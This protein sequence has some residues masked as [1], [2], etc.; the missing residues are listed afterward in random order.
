ML[1]T[2][3]ALIA[4]LAEAEEVKQVAKRRR[5]PRNIWIPIFNKRIGEVVAAA[6]ADRWQIPVAL[7]ELEDG[8]V[9]RILMRNVAGLRV[10]RDHE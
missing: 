2:V 3:A 7:D 4:M 6:I 1:R 8:N 9:V 5:I 10:G